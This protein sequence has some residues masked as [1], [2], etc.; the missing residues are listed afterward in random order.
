MQST[1]LGTTCGAL[2]KAHRIYAHTGLHAPRTHVL[3]TNLYARSEN[4]LSIWAHKQT[5]DTEEMHPA[6]KWYERK[7]IMYYDPIHMHIKIAAQRL[8]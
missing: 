2:A 7:S 3:D 1:R 4:T 6:F 8:L 5:L